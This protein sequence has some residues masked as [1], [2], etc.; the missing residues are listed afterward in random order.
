MCRYYGYLAQRL[1]RLSEVLAVGTVGAA[2]GAVLTLL[3]HFPGW[4]TAAAAATAAVGSLILVVGRYQDKA[5]RSADIRRRLG[6]VTLEWEELWS[7]VYT[8]DD[9]ELRAQ[10]AALVRRQGAIIERA[11]VELPLSR[12]LARRSEREAD[13]YWTE[14]HAEG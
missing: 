11:P 12:P 2:S 6:E 3:S 5:A 7:E 9:A 13:R 4:V 8:R 1:N 10:W 14:R